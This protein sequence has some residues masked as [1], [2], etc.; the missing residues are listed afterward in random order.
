MAGE[1]DE[2]GSSYR[3]SIWDLDRG[4]LVMRSKSEEFTDFDLKS[5]CTI[6]SETKSNKRDTFDDNQFDR[7]YTRTV[8]D[9]LVLKFVSVEEKS[10]KIWECDAGIIRTVKR[11]NLKQS[12]ISAVSSDMIGFLIVLG[13]NGSV[14]ILNSEGSYVSTIERPEMEFTA[15]ACS[16]E[17]LYLG[18]FT[19]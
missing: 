15:I 3:V 16:N 4:S 1:Q 7:R 11:M 5:I 12:L 6:Q 19:G 8:R 17:N 2:D 13:R 18:T 10:I 14:L 9:D